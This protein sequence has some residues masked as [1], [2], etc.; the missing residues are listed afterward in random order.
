MPPMGEP[1]AEEGNVSKLTLDPMLLAKAKGE[2]N[3]KPGGV[4]KLNVTVKATDDGQFEVVDTDELMA[5]TENSSEPT[6]AP[7][8][9]DADDAEESA[10]L[11]YSRPK[12]KAKPVKMNASFLKG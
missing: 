12:N 4:Y 8:E 10:V 11:G 9:P 3:C 1:P 2:Q 7:A 6:E 5:D